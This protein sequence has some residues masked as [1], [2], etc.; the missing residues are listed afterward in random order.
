MRGACRSF[1]GWG[2]GEERGRALCAPV[3]APCAAAA[4]RPAGVSWWVLDW[5][6]PRDGIG[7]E[8]RE[9]G[10]AEPIW[11]QLARDRTTTRRAA[12]RTG[13]MVI[14]RCRPG[15]FESEQ[16]RERAE[17]D[18]MRGARAQ[19]WSGWRVGE[20]SWASY[21]GEGC[22]GFLSLFL[23]RCSFSLSLS[24]RAGPVVACG[25]RVPP[26][27][28]V[29]RRQFALAAK[30]GDS[31][32]PYDAALFCGGGG[33][34]AAPMC[35]WRGDGDSGEAVSLPLWALRPPPS[36]WELRLVPARGSRMHGRTVLVDGGRSSG[37]VGSFLS[38]GASGRTSSRIDGV[39]M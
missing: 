22:R 34:D 14:L 9:G 7:A 39:Q 4:S 16:E 28:L 29:G 37:L 5:T 35:V 3:A 17:C 19:I 23:F 33:A 2:L 6:S 12:A 11:K 21:A 38:P 18:A 32:A 13:I 31:A 20:R 27:L 15:E 8:A 26:A 24:L 25:L 30:C 1:V 10:D 36:P